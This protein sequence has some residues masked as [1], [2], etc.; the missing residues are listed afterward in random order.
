MF[1]EDMYIFGESCT[2]CQHYAGGPKGPELYNI[3]HS[4]KNIMKTFPG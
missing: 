4:S 1:M 3:T 2:E